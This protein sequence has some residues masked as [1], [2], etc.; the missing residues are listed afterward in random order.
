M[1]SMST[2]LAESLATDVHLRADMPPIVPS[3]SRKRKRQTCVFV[4]NPFLESSENHHPDLDGR[5]LPSPPQNGVIDGYIKIRWPASRGQETNVA[6]GR[7]TLLT[8]R[9]RQTVINPD[10][11]NPLRLGISL[12]PPNFSTGMRLSKT[13]EKLWCFRMFF[14]CASVVPYFL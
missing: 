8:H 3:V 13:E 11:S 6:Y 7:G 4:S 12:L 9:S 1:G 5:S 2:Q 10:D 14:S